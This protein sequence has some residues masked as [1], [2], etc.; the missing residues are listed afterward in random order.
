MESGGVYQIRA[1]IPGCL[2]V[3]AL[4]GCGAKS[5]PDS[6]SPEDPNARHA[7]SDPGT[8]SYLGLAGGAY[9]GG[10]TM[11]P[12]HRALGISQANGVRPLDG[13]GAPAQTGKIV[14]LSI[15]MSNTTQEFCNPSPSGQCASGSFV[16][17]ALADPDVQTS[18]LVMVDG[19]RGGQTAGTWDA[20]TD[21]NYDQVRDTRLAPAGVTERQVQ[22]AWV[23][24]ANAGPTVSLPAVTADAYTLVTQIGGIARA[25][26]IRYP[27][28]RLVFLSNRT[29]AGYATTSLNPEPYAYE[30]GFAVKWVIG[31][32]IEQ[33]A[34]GQVD[35]RAGNL[36]VPGSGPWLAWGP[37]L[38]ANGMSPRADGL[39]WAR[40]DFG[41]DGTH[42]SSAGVRKVGR[43]L[44]DFL[45]LSPHGGCWFV[46]GASCT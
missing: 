36:A 31:A 41:S 6:N 24:V 27:N 8:W 2:A 1:K 28:L 22:V 32:Q 26:R 42:P 23:K 4:V 25:L 10:A 34:T 11:P 9:A 13:N 30:S 3:M 7:L 29:Y 40:S 38:W 37:D 16:Q 19:A 20:P 17:Q 45:R 35:P 15:G 46:N 12:A 43:L 39:T 33:M 5:L 14:L 44:L 21:P 18:S